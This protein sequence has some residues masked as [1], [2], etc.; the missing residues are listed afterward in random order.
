MT[1]QLK[2]EH[3]T[4]WD[5]PKSNEKPLFNDD[6]STYISEKSSL[7]SLRENNQTSIPN[8]K[9]LLTS[10]LPRTNL[11]IKEPH[12]LRYPYN[13]L[14][15]N[16]IPL[17]TQFNNARKEEKKRRKAFRKAPPGQGNLVSLPET[18]SN[19]M[20]ENYYP[21][22]HYYKMKNPDWNMRHRQTTDGQLIPYD[23]IDPSQYAQEPALTKSPTTPRQH[24][25]K[26]HHNNHGTSI[27]KNNPDQQRYEPVPKVS[28]SS[29]P[30]SHEN[31]KQ[32]KS[33]PKQHT[34]LDD[35]DNIERLN[36]PSKQRSSQQHQKLKTEND[37]NDHSVQSMTE[38]P[39]QDSNNLPITFD[40]SA[41]RP[42]HH[43]K[44]INDG[45]T[46]ENKKH[47]HVH[48]HRRHH[49]HH[50]SPTQSQQPHHH[51]HHHH[52]SPIQ[53]QQQHPH[54]HHHHHHNHHYMSPSKE[55]IDSEFQVID[56]S[57]KKSERT[58]YFQR[59]EDSSHSPPPAIYNQNS[60]LPPITSNYN[61]G[62]N[63]T[64]YYSIHTLSKDWRDSIKPP[65]IYKADPQTKFYD[66]YLNSVIDKKL[67]T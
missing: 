18:K 47:S 8:N 25:R 17:A 36:R 28:S 14:P 12:T 23:P 40:A 26:S 5:A 59:T 15:E 1:Y 53:S 55:Y 41:H 42:K 19:A 62:S 13:D 11:P 33:L 27:M 45:S 67:A 24:H 51:H 29:P 52:H 30:V 38:K 66:R 48:H 46:G 7:V 32:Q 37:R 65:Q 57:F 16:G 60:Y 6:Q 61:S 56:A 54:R 21:Y 9:Q 44:T 49:H 50:H 2:K 31:Y 10:P 4:N 20:N 39:S 34:L 64:D 43:S 22:W 3:L 35:A 63:L 58:P